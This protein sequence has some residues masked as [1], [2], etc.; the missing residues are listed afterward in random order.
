[1][2]ILDG[3]LGHGGKEVIINM[4]QKGRNDDGMDDNLTKRDLDKFRKQM[5]SDSNR[6]ENKESILKAGRKGFNAVRHGLNDV[7]KSLNTPDS[8]KRPK[9]ARIPNLRHADI[10][11]TIN[12]DKMKHQDL[13]GRDIRGKRV[14]PD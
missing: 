13:I 11:T 14:K 6:T 5:R 12:L 3:G 9:I 8:K 4:S 2:G 1:M 7:A 10:N